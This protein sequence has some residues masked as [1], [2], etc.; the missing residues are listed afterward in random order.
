M[1]PESG[2]IITERGDTT[3]L[4][5]ADSSQLHRSSLAKRV[6]SGIGWNA[7]SSLLGQV[8]GFVRSVVIARLLLPDDFGLFSMALTIVLGLNALT[9]IGLDQTILARQFKNDK[10]LHE[11]L[12]TIWSAELVRSFFLALLVLASAYPVAHFYGQP[13]LLSLMPI[14]SLTT[15]IDGCQNVGLAI[16]RKQISFVRI[17]WYEVTTN[18]TAAA[19]TIVVVITTRSV[20]ALV[21]GQLISATLGTTLSYAFHP[22]RPRFAFERTAFRR[23]LN[24]GKFALIIALAS[25][26]TTMADNVVVGR[27]LGTKALGNYALAYS[28]ASFPIGVVVFA[29]SKVTLPAFAEL[30]ASVPERLGHAFTK[31]FTISSLILVTMLVPL[32]LLSGDIVKVLYGSRWT[33]AGPA[34]RVLALIIPLRGLV[35]IISSLFFSLNRPRAVATGKFLEALVFLLLLYPL[36]RAFGLTGAAWAGVITYAVALVNRLIVLGS[37]VPGLSAKLIRVSVSALA[38]GGAGLLI[39]A[40][41]LSF[42]HSAVPRLLLGGLLATT[43]PAL[44]LLLMRADLRKWIAETAH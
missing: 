9:T 22:Y 10:E 18:I 21:F 3:N 1:E 27:L 40:F 29:L 8:I 38:A 6:R 30:A 17:F 31:V 23:A 2:E 12:N 36:T 28:L 25:Y 26:V 44:L 4:R 7:S 16:L 34:L 39:A 24:F 37:V 5:L 14:L 41:G 13:K 42:L 15:L 20:W 11:H 43:V 19:L 33:A 32:F 35:L